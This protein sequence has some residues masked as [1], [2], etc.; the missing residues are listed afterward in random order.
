MSEH[1]YRDS[2]DR[3]L[4]ELEE[5][6]ELAWLEGELLINEDIQLPIF[7]VNGVPYFD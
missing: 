1:Y 6:M 4:V 2:D 5:D 3:P 7:V